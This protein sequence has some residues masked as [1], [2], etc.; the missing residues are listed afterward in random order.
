M[1]KE[2]DCELQ[3]KILQC[4]SYYFSFSLSEKHKAEMRDRNVLE[5]LQ[6]KDQMIEDLEQVRVMSI[7]KCTTES[8]ISCYS[9]V[10]KKLWSPPWATVP[11]VGIIPDF[12][13]LNYISRVLFI[14]FSNNDHNSFP[15][16]SKILLSHFWL[17]FFSNLVAY[18]SSKRISLFHVKAQKRHNSSVLN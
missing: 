11:P 13:H 12:S 8:D 5:I 4:L 17:F 6:F 14:V 10:N 16:Y 18:I 15:I 7:H 1:I 9:G 3:G 2:V